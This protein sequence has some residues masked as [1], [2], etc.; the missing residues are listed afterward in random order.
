MVNV[1][2]IIRGLEDYIKETPS[3]PDQD[4]SIN[5]TEQSDIETLQKFL[6]SAFDYGYIYVKQKNK[7]DDLEIADL[8]T[9]EGLYNFVGDIQQVEVKYPYYKNSIRSR[10]HASIVLTTTKGAYSF[11]IRNASGGVVPDQINL[12]RGGSKKD[13]KLNKANISKID[14]G[15]SELENILSQND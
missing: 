6:G 2:K 12:V 11:D 7:K 1:E 15:T 10:K 4:K 8:T 3:Q 13:E 14:L 5:P 9:E